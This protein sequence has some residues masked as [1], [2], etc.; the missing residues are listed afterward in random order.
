MDANMKRSIIL[1]N[2]QEPKNRGIPDED[3]YLKINKEYIYL[4]NEILYF[5]S[6]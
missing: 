6:K 5:L 1:D 4:S 3:N 2:Y